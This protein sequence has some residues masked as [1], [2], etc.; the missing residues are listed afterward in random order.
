MRREEKNTGHQEK[1][2][3][4]SSLFRQCVE[5]SS[6]DWT[7]LIEPLTPPEDAAHKFVASGS[8]AQLCVLMSL[9]RAPALACVAATLGFLN[10]GLFTEAATSAAVE[11]ADAHAHTAALIAGLNFLVFVFGVQ[12]VLLPLDMVGG[13]VQSFFEQ[14]QIMR[15][16]RSEA[17]LFEATIPYLKKNDDIEYLLKGMTRHIRSGAVAGK[18]CRALRSW[19]SQFHLPITQKGGIE[20]VTACLTL[21]C[22]LEGVVEQGCW[23]L[24]N[25]AHTDARYKDSICNAGGVE[26]VLHALLLHPSSPQVGEQGCRVLRNVA[27]NNERARQRIIHAQG[28]ERIVSVMVECGDNAGVVEKGCG[29]LVNLISP[30]SDPKVLVHSG[31]IKQVIKAMEHHAF[32]AK[33]QEQGVAF[34]L[35]LLHHCPSLKETVRERGDKVARGAAEGR[36]STSSTKNKAYQ[37]IRLLKPGPS[38]I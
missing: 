35:R 14:V 18:G 23:V 8:Y 10:T 5:E 25:L 38:S 7:A 34:L 37:V 33:V 15:V 28:L 9:Y 32:N 21:H 22:D 19:V 2:E 30:L 4:D 6:K 24:L 1:G 31:A 20:I 13:D 29:V 3:E 11:D 36:A 17:L 16:K 27:S 12:L 26:A